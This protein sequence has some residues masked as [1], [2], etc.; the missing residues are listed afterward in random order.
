MK[1]TWENGNM[2][3]NDHGKWEMISGAQPPPSLTCSLTRTL[4]H[5]HSLTRSLTRSLPRGT[6]YGV[7]WSGGQSTQVLCST[8]L[9][10]DFI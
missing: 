1:K 3:K 2:K 10:M 4:P 9:D 8:P 6:L 5:T 7:N